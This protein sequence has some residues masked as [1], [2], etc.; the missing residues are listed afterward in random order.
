MEEMNDD[1]PT[2]GKGLAEHS[3]IPAKLSELIAALAE[4]LEAHQPT[5]D[6]TDERSRQELDAYVKLARAHRAIAAQL[7]EA[8]E[9]MAGY[10][11]L[12]MGRH[13]ERALAGRSVLD[14]FGNLVR[15]ERELVALLQASVAQHEAL[16]SGIAATA[17]ADGLRA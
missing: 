14:A 15:V 1:V 17:P 10:R 2:C 4:N 16:L 11:D 7:R 9:Q 5:L 3:A 8:A 12:P 13:D 6:L